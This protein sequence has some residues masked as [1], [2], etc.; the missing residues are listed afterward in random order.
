[1]PE[2]VF[3]RLAAESGTNFVAFCFDNLLEPFRSGRLLVNRQDAP[4]ALAV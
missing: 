4:T 1:V 2:E 3:T